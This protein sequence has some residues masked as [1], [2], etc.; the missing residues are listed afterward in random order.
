MMKLWKAWYHGNLAQQFIA[1]CSYAA[2]WEFIFLGIAKLF[3]N[4]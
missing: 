2:L 1:V 3:R 4:R